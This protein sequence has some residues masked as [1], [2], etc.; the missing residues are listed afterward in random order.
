M[1]HLSGV[2]MLKK[3]ALAATLAI[4]TLSSP[5]FAAPTD[6]DMVAMLH[7]ID[8]RVEN[9]GDYKSLVYI[10][11]KETDKTDV[12]FQAVVYR[13]DLDD[14]LV[15]L[16]V[17]PQAEAGKGYLRVDNNLFMYDP[18]V[19]KWERRTE[20]ERIGG[21]GSQRSDFDQSRLAIEYTPSFVAEETLGKYKVNHIKLTAKEGVDVAYPVLELW[22]DQATGN[23]LK[24]QDFALSGKLMRT[25]YYP[26]WQKMH[27]ETKNAD[28]YFAKEIRI[29]D[30]IEK[31]NSTTI[32]IQEVDLSALDDSIFTKAW[33][34]SK[35]R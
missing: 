5:A 15:I 11:Q 29:F 22:L 25:T 14:K 27:S 6:T 33:L 17:K 13:R 28:V 3:L 21:T 2:T 31:G 10:Q 8:E 30:E 7:T 34:E 24:R 20:R 35:S 23:E 26:E 1:T 32:V 19:G 16:F 4:A 18:T 12:V 9:N